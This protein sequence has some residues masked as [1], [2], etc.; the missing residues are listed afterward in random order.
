MSTFKT[1]KIK[2]LPIPTETNVSEMPSTL[3]KRIRI[4]IGIFLA[5]LV[6]VFLINLWLS[7]MGN[8]RISNTEVIFKPIIF[9]T[10]E[11][12]ADEAS[13]NILI[14][15][16]WGKWHEWWSLTDSLMLANLNPNTKK[17]TLL[18]IP[19]DLFVA[20]GKNSAGRINALYGLWKENGEWINLLAKKV[21]EITGQ[22]IHHYLVI[23]FSGFKELVDALGWIE[24]DVPHDLV[25][26]EYPND[27]WGYTTFVVRT[28]R[29]EFDGATAL[30]YARSRHSTSDF[31]RSER[32]QLLLKAIKNRVLQTEILTSPTK[33]QWVYD[34][35]VSHIDSDLTLGN[36]VDIGLKFQEIPSDQIYIYNLNNNCFWTNCS[37]GAYLYTPSREYFGW[38]S[39]VIPEGASISKLSTYTDIIRFTNLIFLFPEL[40]SERYPINI[41]TSKS[42]EKK[43][44]RL[45]TELQKLWIQ[46]EGRNTI[47]LTWS[48]DNSHITI[49]RNEEADIG[50][51]EDASIIKAL[52][53]LDETIP[54]SF[55]NHNEYITDSGP[56][57]EIILGK[58]IDSYFTFAKTPYYL[59]EIESSTGKENST[60]S[61]EIKIIKTKPGPLST[62]KN[63][64]KAG[65]GNPS[66]YIVQPGQWEDF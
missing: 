23:D 48:I 50:F 37:A 39:A 28:W 49:Y 11:K 46:F 34:S 58:D 7:A 63:Q 12:K 43:A 22:P 60:N 9:W 38:A 27:N 17:V 30:K 56:R 57:I 47:L 29:Q 54:Y 21:S 33:I 15:G 13:I 20:Y 3:K 64:G 52:K 24:V 5:V 55:T 10:S 66:E 41:I 42:N 40:K 62:G 61:S 2:S 6:S 18:S 35:L 45:Y 32:Q 8:V 25:D 65:G 4:G 53:F 44:K 26:Y 16:I 31:D 14:A 59:P 19:R 1:K 36:L 51:K